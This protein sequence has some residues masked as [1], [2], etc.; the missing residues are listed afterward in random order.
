MNPAEYV[1]RIPTYLAVQWDGTTE[2]R[3]WI[4]SVY[5]GLATVQDDDILIEGPVYPETLPRDVWVLAT[6]EGQALGY[7]TDE[8][9]QRRYQA[10]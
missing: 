9:F 1:D 3:D 7:F 8:D 6:A 2:A 10:K 5:G 4:V